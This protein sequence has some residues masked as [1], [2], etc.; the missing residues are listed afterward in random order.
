MVY[1]GTELN[2]PLADNPRLVWA[3]QAVGF[4][5]VVGGVCLVV[6]SRERTRGAH[7]QLGLGTNR[8][9]GDGIRGCPGTRAR[10]N[11]DPRGHAD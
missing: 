9:L 7:A 5:A 8:V 1:H 3:G 2:R 11:G 4:T 6:L 10:R